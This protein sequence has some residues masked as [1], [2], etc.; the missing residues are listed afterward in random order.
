MSYF[1]IIAYKMYKFLVTTR[2]SSRLLSIFFFIPLNKSKTLLQYSFLKLLSILNFSLRHIFKTLPHTCGF[3]LSKVFPVQLPS[4]YMHHTMRFTLIGLLL[5]NLAYGDSE[6]PVELNP[7]RVV[8]E[9]GGSVSVNCSTSV[10]HHGM[11][12]EVSEGAVP[13]S[14]DNLI[15]WRVSNLT[16][17]DIQPFCYLNHKK[18]CQLELPVTIYKT[19]D[20]VS[21]S[22]VNHTGPMM[23][24]NQYELQCDVLNVAPVQYLT[25]KWYKGQTLVDQTNF[26]DTIKTPVDKTVTL[27]IRPDRADDG[28][29]Y[30][31][32]AE[33]ELGEEGPQP[34]PKLTSDPLNITVYYKPTINE[35]KLPSVVPLFRGYSVVIVCEADG[36]PKPTISWNISTN[37]PVYSETFTITDSTPEDLYCIAD[38]SVDT[39]IRHV[40]VSVQDSECPVELNPQRVV[41]EYGGSVSVDCKTYVLHHGM[42]WEASEGAVPQSR[43]TLITWRVSNLTQWDIEPFCYLNHKKQCQL[44]L[45]VTVYKTP[46]SVSISTVNH[47]GPMMEGNQYELQCDVLNVAPVQYL[48][49]KWYKGQ[50]LVDQTNFTDT[51]KTPV[52][53]TVTL[54]IRPDRAD[55]GVQYRCEAELEL[56]AEGPQPPP[57][58]TSDPLSITVYY[59]PQSNLCEDWSPKNG[60]SLVSY[61][62]L[63]SLEGNPRPNISWRRKSSL[64]N[65]S[66]PLNTNDSGKYE[67]TA[68]N[69][70]GHFMCT[71]NITVEYAPMIHAS[72]E[73][74]SE[75]EGSNI[76]LEC[77]WTGY[78][79]PDVWWSFN[80][81]NISTGRRHIIE[82]ARSTSAGVYTCS[83]MNKFGRKDKNVVVEIRGNP[84]NYIPYVVILVFFVLLVLLIAL[85]FC[86]WKKKK[87]SGSYEVQS[88]KEY[89]LRPLSNGGNC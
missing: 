63:N 61:P 82:R 22:T 57:K 86:M 45:P 65:A 55:D 51:T 87:S 56:G 50:T 33:L 81:K 43:D 35:T 5:I 84:P 14:R 31:C 39:D 18:Q 48:T 38:N 76:I 49:V 74:F 37:N 77:N 6:C 8:V 72:Q 27:M 60:T 75:E 19:P 4:S 30:R 36:N 29:Q 78:P 71:I 12:W 62:I 21:I 23:E 88:A 54:M 89:E 16:Q 70:L 11:G 58:V 15:T 40:K 47:T 69:E 85:L 25:V 68:S 2:V 46:D 44:E 83:A 79:E 52:N 17:W 7:Q 41:V 28:A 73:K 59:K 80:N 13:Q 3:P 64:L 26:T 42:G 66:V 9:Y 10:T 24:G 34:P 53:K 20:S 32:E 67:I 1:W